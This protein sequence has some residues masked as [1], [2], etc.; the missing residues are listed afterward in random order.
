MPNHLQQIVVRA[1]PQE[2]CVEALKTIKINITNN[3]ICTLQAWGKGTC[4][5]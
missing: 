1:F 4:Y 5:V 2:E 3:H